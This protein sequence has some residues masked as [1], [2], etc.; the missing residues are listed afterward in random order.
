MSPLGG[1]RGLLRWLLPLAGLTLLTPVALVGALATGFNQLPDQA[2][3]SQLASADIPP[4]LLALYEQAVQGCPGLS[5]AVLAGVGKVES[6]HDRPPGQVSTAGAQ[7]PMQFLP[8][9]WTQARVD[10]NSDGHA[11]PFEPADAIPAAAAY[12]CSLGA[13]RDTPTAVAA[14]TCGSVVLCRLRAL[15][16]G[17]YATRVLGWAARYANAGNPGGPAAAVAVQVA[18]SQVGTPYV[19]G[20]ESPVSGF[21]CS[22][23]VQ[24]AYARAGGQL[25]RVAQTQ[26]DTG[27]GLPVGT[28]PAPGDLVFFGTDTAHVTHVGIALGQQR[29]VD[30]PHTGALVRVEPIAGFGHYLGATRPSALANR[31]APSSAGARS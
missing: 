5:W 15:E 19:W 13:D 24:Y 22:G 20:G 10:G 23:L 12:L 26:H 31:H 14:Y 8:S 28:D 25:P 16:A 17:G 18:L 30:A 9:T 1:T 4:D 2:G 27:P 6:D 7:G 3:R 11:D 29:M 21:D